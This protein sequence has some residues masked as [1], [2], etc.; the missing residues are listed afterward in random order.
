MDGQLLSQLL[1][2]VLKDDGGGE[3]SQ[4]SASLPRELWGGSLS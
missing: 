1:I 4:S 2:L 3:I